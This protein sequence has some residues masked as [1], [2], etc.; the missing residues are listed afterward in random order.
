MRVKIGPY[1]NWWGPYQIADLLQH[2]GVHED[3]CHQYGKWLSNTWVGPFCQWIHDKRKRTMKIH[4]DNY[5]VWSMDSTLS[6]IILPMLVMLREK[7]H[8][9]PHV[10]DEDV[11]EHLRSTNAP[12]TEHEWDTD[13]LF[14]KRWE[15]VLDE[16]IWAFEHLVNDDW[17]E[18]FFTGVRDREFVKVGEDEEGDDLF[19]FLKGPNDTSHYDA[20]GHRAF[21]K[22][23]SNGTR[24]FGTY[25]QALWD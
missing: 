4:I 20:E 2:V 18:Q 22:R 15:W 1:L 23:I 14:H 6:P 12:P 19:E 24:L 21:Q 13:E 9:S 3:K 25:F 7:K 5:D 17:E 11:P 16:M 8:G 10:A